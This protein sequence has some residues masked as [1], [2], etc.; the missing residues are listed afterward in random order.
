MVI[1][2]MLEQSRKV[3]IAKAYVR[4]LARW[5]FAVL[6]LAALISALGVTGLR[7]VQFDPDVL[8]YFDRKMPERQALEAIEDR[9][10]RTNEVVFVLRARRGSVLDENGLGAI[11]FL[12]EGAQRLPDVITTRS[13]LTL[14]TQSPDGRAGTPRAAAGADDIRAAIKAAGFAARTVISEDETVAAV[15]AIV[16]RNSRKDIDIL[17]LGDA[18][19]ALQA[20]AGRRF[21]G[22]EI[23]LTGRLMMDNAFLTEGQQDTYDYAALQLAVLALI[24]FITFRSAF[25]TVVLSAMVLTATLTAIGIVGLTG[26]PLNGISSAAPSVLV[27]LAVAAGVH[28]VMAW[29][30]ALRLGQSGADAVAVA[31]AA[32]A[33]PVTLSVITTLVSFLC[34]NLAASPPFRQLGNVVTFGLGIS[35]LMFFTLLP[36]L[37]LTAPQKVT[38]QGL[39]LAEWMTRL[40]R[41]TIRRQRA[42][43]AAFAATT[44]GAIAGIAQI[45]FDDTFSHYFDKRFEIRRATDLFEEK[46]SGTIFVDFSVPV[47][48]GERP[49][50]SLHLERL[51]AFSQW[52]ETQPEVALVLSLESIARDLAKAAPG[53]MTAEGLPAS[54]AG[55]TALKALYEQLHAKGMIGLVD[56]AGRHS[57]VNVVLRGVSSA[58]TLAF[59][60]AAEARARGIFG[61]PV[62]STGLPILSAQLSIESS[63]SMLISTF[64]ALAVISLMLIFA[65]GNLRLG[66]ISLLPNLI[67]AVAAFGLWGVMVGEVSFAATVVSALTFGIVVDD[68]IH[69]LMKYRDTRQAGL[70]PEAA[71]E[72]TFRSVGVPV[73]AT[74]VALAVSFAVFTFSGFLVNQHLGWLTAITITAALI[75]DLLFLPPLLLAAEK[76]RSL[77]A[78]MPRTKAYPPA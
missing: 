17:K 11:A 67:P 73:M 39:V 33:A 57:R 21:P 65:L 61:G 18:A 45:T 30:T 26:F 31:L 62:L 13:I 20:E 71:I 38:S 58:D 48:P 8:V 32:T 78:A 60:K 74:S 42:L 14:E 10:G 70:G 16:P 53:V 37:L 64:A 50:G 12:Q 40:A 35:L 41:F 9:F 27:G 43:L 75:A 77:G 3:R 1:A 59:S 44:I 46:L 54:P 22:I 76:S 55:E 25:A 51:K 23:L 63:Q 5:K 69:I 24:L 68:T 34:L 72:E 52:L 56:D 28:I 66:L 6:A 49:F 19:K 15:A 29:Q 2:C 7:Q 4:W 36:A 47:A